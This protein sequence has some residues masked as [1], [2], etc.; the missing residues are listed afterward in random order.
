MTNFSNMVLLV[1]LLLYTLLFFY[2]S[3]FGVSKWKPKVKIVEQLKVIEKVVEKQVEIYRELEWSGNDATIVYPNFITGNIKCNTT[4]VSQFTFQ[5]LNRLEMQVT[6]WTDCFSVGLFVTKKEFEKF[7]NLNNLKEHLLKF[8]FN[9]QVDIHLCFGDS[10]KINT[11]RNLSIKYSKSEIIFILDID[12]IISEDLQKQVIKYGNPKSKV[13]YAFITMEYACSRLS[14]DSCNVTNYYPHGQHMSDYEKWKISEEP[15]EVIYNFP[16][17][18][19]IIVNKSEIPEFSP[20]FDF[21]GKYCFI[22]NVLVIKFHFFLNLE[23]WGINLKYYLV[24]IWHIFHILILNIGLLDH[25]K[26]L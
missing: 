6:R 26:G 25:L 9:N 10:Y 21:G 14:L 18:P 22:F 23:F 5:R 11:M 19:Y 7:N 17:E 12:W 20:K 24:V 3:T 16:Y 1:G 2:Y 8:K 13:P 4:I 15:Y